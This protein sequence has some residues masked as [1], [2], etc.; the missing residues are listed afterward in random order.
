MKEKVLLLLVLVLVG[1]NV[2]KHSEIF[3]PINPSINKDYK[4][5]YSIFAQSVDSVVLEKGNIP[6]SMIRKTCVNDSL[7]YILDDM[8]TISVY[9]IENGNLIK[10]IQKVG[11]GDGEYIEPISIATDAE[12]VYILDMLQLSILMYDHSLNYQKKIQVPLHSFDFIKTSDGFLLWNAGGYDQLNTY[13]HIDSEGKLIDSYITPEMELDQIESICVFSDD[14]EGRIYALQTV[15]DT[16]YEWKEN[17]MRAFG[18]LDFCS[19]SQM[20]YKSSSEKIKALDVCSRGQ[21]FVSQRFII[22]QYYNGY[23]YMTNI[24]DRQSARSYCG[25]VKTPDSLPFLPCNLHK[26]VLYSISNKE[27]NNEEAGNNDIVLF[28]YKLK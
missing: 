5:D 3:I 12:H 22:T 28:K 13:V 6:L 14:G 10:Q 16:I 2:D 15:S 11:H 26:N 25:V 4:I 19:T 27:L 7:L 24:Y 17:Q 21:S 9:N 8:K 1:C 20:K 18:T 23:R